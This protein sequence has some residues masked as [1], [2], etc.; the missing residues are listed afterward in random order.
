MMMVLQS[1]KLTLA[2]K[3]DLKIQTLSLPVDE[4]TDDIDCPLCGRNK[5]FRITRKPDSLLYICHRATCGV[6]GAIRS[7]VYGAMQS[8][9]QNAANEIVYTFRPNKFMGT[10]EALP[11]ASLEWLYD[12]YEIT[13]GD[14][15]QWGWRYEKRHHRLLMPITSWFGN[16][17]GWA[18]K[19]M[20]G[21]QYAGGKVIKYHDT[22]DPFGL[23]FPLTRWKGSMDNEWLVIVEDIISCE[24]VNK[25]TPAVALLGTHM[26]DRQ[27]HVIASHYP[28][29]IV[30]LDPD[31]LVKASSLH[32]KYKGIFKNLRL[33]SLM[34]DPKDT[35]VPHMKKILNSVR[36]TRY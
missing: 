23:H 12:K 11:I 35:T 18:A 25:F 33:V 22:D 27:A 5:S 17:S 1:S 34:N 9:A 14:V 26:N 3:N 7:S 2:Q 6:S 16:R 36:D 20:P 32:G 10:M 13:G 4:T 15:E 21:S 29:A 24:K 31:A 19:K 8:P 28:N 30:M